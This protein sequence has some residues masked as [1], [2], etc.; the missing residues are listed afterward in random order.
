MNNPGKLILVRHGETKLNKKG[1]AS[2]DDQERL[3]GWLDVPLDA[4][5]LL[6]AKQLGDQ[7]R[8]THVDSL[9]SSPLKRASETAF[10]IGV[11]TGVRPVLDPRLKPW[12]LGKLAGQKVKDILPVMEHLQKPENRDIPAPDGE[13]FNDFLQRFLPLLAEALEEAQAGK[14]VVLVC[15]TR[16]CQAARAWIAAGCEGTKIKDDVMNDYAGEVPPGGVMVV[17]PQ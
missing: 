5:G 13:S 14:D 4:N 15:H 12:N 11:G 9:R 17:A 1:G 16:N 2:V 3:R 10:R 7:F 8:G 6:Q